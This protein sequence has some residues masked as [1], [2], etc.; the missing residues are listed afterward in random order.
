MDEPNIGLDPTT[1]MVLWNL[2]QDLNNE[3]HTI[4]LCPHDMYE[5][6]MLCDHV[7]IMNQG[8]LIAFDTPQG[9]KIA[10]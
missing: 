8:K 9:L 3:G 5:V 6:E 4:I 1:K 7:G 10:F 2:I